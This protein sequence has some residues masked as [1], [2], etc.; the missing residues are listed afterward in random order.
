MNLD[1]ELDDEDITI[2]KVVLKVKMGNKM[3][4]NKSKQIRSAQVAQ[5]IKAERDVQK[6]M[7][8][9][10]SVTAEYTNEFQQGT[11][12]FCVSHIRTR[13]NDNSNKES[14]TKGYESKVGQGFRI[15][16]SLDIMSDEHVFGLQQVSFSYD[17]KAIGNVGETFCQSARK[18]RLFNDLLTTKGNI[19]G[20]WASCWT[21]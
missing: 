13:H 1:N 7:V 12:G 15:D 14:L 5:L 4:I 16:L 6:A 3:I 10:D 18:K 21:S 2:K 19:K 20:L 9:F 11:F 17:S 8:I